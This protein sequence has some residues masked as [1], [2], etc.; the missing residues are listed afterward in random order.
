M[1]NTT[2]LPV[3]I[4]IKTN[5]NCPSEIVEKPKMQKPICSFYL[6]NKCNRGSLC[7]FFHPLRVNPQAPTIV[8][9]AEKTKEKSDINFKKIKKQEVSFNWKRSQC[10]SVME[11]PLP[12]QPVSI[13]KVNTSCMVVIYRRFSKNP[14]NK[15]YN[16]NNTFYY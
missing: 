9:G 3:Q 16:T 2:K 13:P 4:V 10:T 7:K 8:G 11:A 14:S 6:K 12:L 15:S 1:R 5:P